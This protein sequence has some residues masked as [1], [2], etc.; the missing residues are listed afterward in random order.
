MLNV[1]LA[2]KIIDQLTECTDYNINIMDDRGIIVASRDKSRVGTFHEIAFEI[3]Q[4]KLEVKEVEAKD[5]FLGTRAGINMALEYERRI[6]GVLSIT[7]ENV[8]SLRPTTG[9]FMAWMLKSP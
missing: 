1:E 9:V 3:V 2:E 8:E 4:K 7:G 6:I 5:N